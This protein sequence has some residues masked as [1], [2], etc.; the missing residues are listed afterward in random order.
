M[1]FGTLSSVQCIRTSLS[2]IEK[3]NY[4][5]SKLGDEA[6]RA[7]AGLAMSH[8]NYAVAV[9]ILRERFGNTQDVVDMH[10]KELLEVQPPTLKVESLRTFLDRV[11]K[12]LCSLEV[13]GESVNQRVFVSMIR[14][15]LPEEAFQCSE[16]LSLTTSNKDTHTAV[17]LLTFLFNAQFHKQAS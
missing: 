6:R 17:E 2:G 8:E 13:L 15:K 9:S 11:E 7:L 10:Y 14:S 4:L 3:F 1:N 12:H 5:Q 16:T